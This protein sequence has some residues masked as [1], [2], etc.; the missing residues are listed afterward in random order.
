MPT[1]ILRSETGRPSREAFGSSAAF[2]NPWIGC[3]PPRADRPRP[4]AA[5][6]KLIACKKERRVMAACAG[7]WEEVAPLFEN[8]C[9]D[10]FM[11][12]RVARDEA[13]SSLNFFGDL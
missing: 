1:R 9:L 2:S 8:S 13:R 3:S 4:S 12:L 10:E 6:P 7:G 5:A 11:N